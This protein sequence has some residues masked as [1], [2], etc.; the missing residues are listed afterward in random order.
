MTTSPALSQSFNRKLIALEALKKEQ[1]QRWAETKLLRY[2]PYSKQLEFHGAG[3]THRERLFLAGN[4]LGK[5]LSGSFEYAMHLTGQY[6]ENWPGRIWTKPIVGWAAGVTG[7]TTRDTV[8]RLLLGRPSAIGT[9]AIPKDC[10]LDYSRALGVADLMDTITVRHVSGEVSTL[11]LKFYEKGREKWQAET[12]DLVWFDEEPPQPI[13]SEGLTRTNATGGMTYITATPLK[14]MTEVITRFLQEQNPDRHVTTMTIDDAEHYTPE[15]RKTIIAGYAPHE[16]DARAKGIPMLGSGR[17][18]PVVE[19]QIFIPQ[20]AIPKHFKTIG[21]LDFGYDHPFAGVRVDYDPDM[22]IVY[23]TRA[24]R[25]REQLPPVHAGALRSW[26]EWIPW[27]WPHDGLNT[28][29]SSGEPLAAD[30]R[31]HGLK[32]CAERATHPEGG[33]S[34]EA[35]I[36]DILERMNTG[37]FKVFDHLEE[38]KQEFRLYHRDEGKIVKINDDLMDATRYAVMMLRHAVQNMGKTKPLKYPKQRFI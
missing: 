4:Q 27:A 11:A 13:Y 38:W 32:M 3:K 2:K 5:T 6:P 26:G 20:F 8:Q 35:G 37:R 28:E 22:D 18:Y 7:E 9:G 10:I 29:K 17:I 21:G 15:Q 1:A 30:Y 12:L 23:V 14:G 36:M 25:V 34:V 16:R 31:K 19:D 24:Y 33:N